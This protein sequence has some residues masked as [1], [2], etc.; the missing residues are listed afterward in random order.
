MVEY[1]TRL[2][3]MNPA[4]SKEKDAPKRDGRYVRLAHANEEFEAPVFTK[5]KSV[6]KKP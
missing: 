2:T 5:G 4:A 1:F 6:Q 3:V